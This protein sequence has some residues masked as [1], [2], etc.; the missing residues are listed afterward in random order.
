MVGRILTFVVPE[1][2]KHNINVLFLQ[3]YMYFFFLNTEYC[4]NEG[5]TDH[6]HRKALLYKK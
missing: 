1:Q 3:N 4:L 6:S 5:H 2:I